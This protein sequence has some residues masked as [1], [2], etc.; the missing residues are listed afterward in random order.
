[1]S[2]TGLAYL[3]RTLT[4]GSNNS[5][6]T[7]EGL[8][9]NLIVARVIDISLNTNSKLFKQ[10]GWGAIGT[11]KYEILDQPSAVIGENKSNTAKPLYPQFK[12]F[13][14]VN[15]LVLLFKLPSTEDP[16]T[17][18]SYEYY[19][20]NPIGIWNH[21]EQNG[22]PSY[23]TN[24]NSPSQ[25]KSY[26]S[27]QAGATNKE[28]N[29]EFELDLNGQSGGNFI[30]NGNIKP[31][32]PF[33]GDNII[34][35]RFGNTIRLGSTTTVDG[36]IVNNWSSIGTQGSPI[37]IIKNGQA[38]VTGSNESWVPTVESINDD[39]TSI[40]LT[41]T[42]RI[43]LEIAT[44]GLAVGESATVPLN[45]IISNTPID[46]RQYSGSQV[47]LNSDRLVF[48][49]KTDNIIMSAQKSI[50]LES[51]EDVGFRSRERNVN[52]SSEKGYVNLGGTNADQAIVL[53]DTFMASFSSLLK[54]LET[55]CSSLSSESSI[56]GTAAKAILVKAQIQSISNNLPKFLSKKVKSV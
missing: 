44:L 29:E 49:S 15:E 43:P 46:P 56:Q 2:V 13:P 32:L 37:T 10:G 23:L 11:I 18:G 20:L 14:L 40:Y 8:K 48:N 54:N 9:D 5:G 25:T 30:E 4:G 47:M 17:A 52:L 38:A 41:S 6:S 27:I 21:P 36:D 50:I 1:M 31:I 22:Y 12:N 28:S 19:Y 26:D 42:Q 39:P 33:A 35:G 34:E 53:G 51:N 45:N 24:L 16:G 3:N 7:I 55:L